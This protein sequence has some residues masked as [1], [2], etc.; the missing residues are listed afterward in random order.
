MKTFQDYLEAAG[1][2][3][4]AKTNKIEDIKSK[5]PEVGRID[6]TLIIPPNV[7][8]DMM[9]MRGGL[10]ISGDTN[11]EI[12]MILKSGKSVQELKFNKES[13]EMLADF[14]DRLGNLTLKQ[15]DKEIKVNVGFGGFSYSPNNPFKN[16]KISNNK[17]LN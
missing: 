7:K 15:G 5:L 4:P 13:Q 9:G 10:G 8:V 17:R 11:D 1:E 2:N 12:K 16:N 6:V 3:L 14:Q